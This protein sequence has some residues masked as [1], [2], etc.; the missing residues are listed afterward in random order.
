MTE[1]C[2]DTDRNEECEEWCHLYS[3][4]YNDMSCT[5][6]KYETLH[7]AIIDYCHSLYKLSMSSAESRKI[8]IDNRLKSASTNVGLTICKGTA[9]FYLVF[10]CPLLF[11]VRGNSVQSIDLF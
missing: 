9:Y 1:S 11:L 10:P 2:L 4:L 7:Q 3:L 5:V 6:P 8:L